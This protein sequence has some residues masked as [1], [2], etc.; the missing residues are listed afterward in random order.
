M[1]EVFVISKN[2]RRATAELYAAGWSG[3]NVSV[4]ARRAVAARRTCSLQRC[5]IDATVLGLGG[6]VLVVGWAAGVAS[7]RSC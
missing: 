7:V 6:K 5:K 4:T 3:A 1:K 2:N